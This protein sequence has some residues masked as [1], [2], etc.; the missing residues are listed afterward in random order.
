[1][2]VRRDRPLAARLGLDRRAEW[3]ILQQVA[4]A[5]LAPE[6]LRVD[7]EHGLL[8]TRYVAAPAWQAGDL[9]QP[10]VLQRLGAA[11]RQ[12]HQLPVRAPVFEP[13]AVAQR[14]AQ[15]L[16]GPLA[17]PWLADIAALASELYPPDAN[18]CLCHHDAHAGNLLGSS[19]PLFVDWEYAALGMPLLDL[20]VVCRFHQLGPR[21]CRQLL[22]AWDASA[23]DTDY[24][25][26]LLFGRFYD[27][28][29]K[30]WQAALRA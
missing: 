19:Q 8:L 22:E 16:P 7:F 30:L 6:P 11:L 14:Y 9:Q 28:L 15:W 17:K 20:A 12:I 24:Q 13:L 27:A 29:V 3:Q 23:T 5:G 25:Q 4:V 10:Q 1:M 2:V 26:L 18:R 21:Q